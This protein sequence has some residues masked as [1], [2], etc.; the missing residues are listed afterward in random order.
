MSHR[1]ALLLLR[2]ILLRGLGDNKSVSRAHSIDRNFLEDE[3]IV[4]ES[5]RV[6]IADDERPARSFLAAIL[7]GFEDVTLV[8]EA[9]NGGEA[10]EVIER[11]KP[12][13]APLVRQCPEVADPAGPG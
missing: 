2:L 5:L 9:E 6:M 11:R 1:V 3:T 10:V 13:L 8:G 4:N 12:D 7:R